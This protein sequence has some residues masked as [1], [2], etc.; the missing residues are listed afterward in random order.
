VHLKGGRNKGLTEEMVKV[1]QNE[2]AVKY[3]EQLGLQA[4]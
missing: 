4:T 1:V 3:L 2:Y